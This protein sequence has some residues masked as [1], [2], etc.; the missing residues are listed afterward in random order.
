MRSITALIIF[1]HVTL[2]SNANP[3][4]DKGLAAANKKE[5]SLASHYFEQVI[6]KE[7]TNSSAYYNLGCTLFEQKKYGEAIWAFEKT[8]QYQPNYPN[9]LR[10]L[11]ICYFKLELPPYEP[12]H[13]GLFRTVN[14]FGSTNWS[15]LAIFFSSLVAIG[16]IVLKRNRFV[17]AR[18]VA[19]LVIILGSSFCAVSCFFGYKSH[20]D[21]H[22]VNGAVV[23]AKSIPT[24]LN[25][26]G[27]QGTLRINEGTR[28]TDFQPT[29]GTYQKAML[30]NGQ[31][32]MI[33]NKDWKKL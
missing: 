8:L 32:V 19:F 12:I 10:N 9:S 28:L 2:F 30:P 22:Y 33:N 21:F 24:F 29:Q 27:E 1:V 16:I 26:H 15:I 17:S 13:S 7:K 6:S 5:Y 14:S 18:R 20:K 11:E 3:L 31:E 25:C 4:F 23:V